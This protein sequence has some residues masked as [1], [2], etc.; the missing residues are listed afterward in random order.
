M[1]SADYI[2]KYAETPETNLQAMSRQ[3]S[4]ALASMHGIGDIYCAEITMIDAGI[5]ENKRRNIMRAIHQLD[6][7]IHNALVQ[8]AS[9]SPR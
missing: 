2:S 8:V 9:P 1:N 4:D 3:C 5:L 7:L 6:N